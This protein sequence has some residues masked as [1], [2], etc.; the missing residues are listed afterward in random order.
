MMKLIKWTEQA[1][2]CLKWKG[3]VEKA[4]TLVEQEEMMLFD[5]PASRIQGLAFSDIIICTQNTIMCGLRNVFLPPQMSI[6]SEHNNSTFM[7][8][9]RHVLR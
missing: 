7:V 6:K 8:L 3:T 2:D 9:Y 5:H 1:Q 4:K